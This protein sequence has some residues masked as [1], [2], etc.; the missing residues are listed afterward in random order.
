MGET[1]SS[2]LPLQRMWERAV[3][4]RENSDT[5]YFCDLVLTA[6][7]TLKLATVGM[8]SP[9]FNGRD[10]HRY[11]LEYDLGRASGIG[12]WASACQGATM[13]EPLSRDRSAGALR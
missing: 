8:L 2:W 7:M 9:V 4:A 6:E 1:N 13:G 12:D 11:R 5:A 3:Q 10:N